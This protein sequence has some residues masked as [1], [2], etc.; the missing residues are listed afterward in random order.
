MSCFFRIDDRDVWNPSNLVANAFIGQALALSKLL[1][2]KTGIGPI[3]DDECEINK[4]DFLQ[5]TTILIHRHR[6]TAN[7]ALR[8]LLEGVASICLVLLERSETRIISVRDMEAFGKERISEL[9]RNMP[10]G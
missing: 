10:L 1:D 2:Q 6:D 5:F 8:I 9:A 7:P 4:G 3:V